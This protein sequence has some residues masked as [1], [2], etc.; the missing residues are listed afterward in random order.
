MEK[1]LFFKGI[2]IVFLLFIL[3]NLFPL[4]LFIKLINAHPK[5]LSLNDQKTQNIKIVRKTLKRIENTI[6]LNL[7]CL[8]KSVTFKLLLNMLGVESQIELGINKSQP[9]SLKAHA[10]LSA[11]DQIIYLKMKRFVKLQTIG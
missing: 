10:Y 1:K 6:P 11:N 3:F 2:G 8:I 9:H 7:S 5:S 4:K